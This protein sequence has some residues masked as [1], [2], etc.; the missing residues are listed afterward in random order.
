M[1]KSV[2]VSLRGKRS[3][4]TAME[5]EKVTVEISSGIPVYVHLV[6]CILTGEGVLF[7]SPVASFL[8]F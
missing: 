6:G 4:G 3:E 8:S 7:C 5:V 1:E 2:R